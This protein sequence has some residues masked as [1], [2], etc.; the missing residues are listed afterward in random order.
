MKKIILKNI[1]HTI[2]NEIC[3]HPNEKIHLLRAFVTW[4]NPKP[5]TGMCWQM[6]ALTA[7]LHWEIKK[8]WAGVM[9]GICIEPGTLGLAGRWWE[10]SVSLS[11]TPLSHSLPDP[12]GFWDSGKRKP[13]ANV[14]SA[15]SWLM[16]VRSTLPTPSLCLAPFS[17]GRG[18]CAH[19]HLFP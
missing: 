19:V 6:G 15:F 8:A 17:G 16:T 3:R 14:L 2:S 4:F 18:G 7:H 1:S 13:H 5:L 9:C 11:W 10:G 12:L